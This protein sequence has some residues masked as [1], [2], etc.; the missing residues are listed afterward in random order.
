MILIIV[1]LAF[2]ISWTW[3]EIT[4]IIF[5]RN[6]LLNTGEIYENKIIWFLRFLA[7][8]LLLASIL[9]IYIFENIKFQQ[10]IDYC[11]GIIK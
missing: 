6:I 8:I 7:S 9:Y 3:I 11:F 5:K 2:I 1:F 10:T 4:F